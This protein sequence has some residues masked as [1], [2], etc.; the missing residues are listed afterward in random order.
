MKQCKIRTLLILF[1]LLIVNSSVS[2]SGGTNATGVSGR[3]AEP[4]TLLDGGFQRLY[5]LKFADA[6]SQ[7]TAWQ[8]AHTEDPLGD[9]SIAAS[10]LFEEFYRQGVLTAKFFLDDKRLLGG[11]DGKPDEKR[12]AG[13]NKANQRARDSARSR[14]QANS[15]DTDALFALTL[16]TG[17]Q[18]DYASILEKRPLEGLSLIKEANGYAS[19]LL[20]LQP[21]RADAWLALGAA[22][23]IIGC[24][25]MHTRFFLWFGG[26]HGDK[27]LGMEQLMRT[28]DGGHYL[29]PF[30]KIF[31]AL[32]AVREKQED[33]ARRELI[34]LVA[35][36]PDNPLFTAELG[37]LTRPNPR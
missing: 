34:D 20:A 37:E 32:A 21:D 28:A 19:R 26:I 22:N 13:F 1:A 24:L 6:R 36:F 17:M 9:V 23:Y 33:V 18:A 35:E 14:I 4:E 15:K 25:P 5:E 2:H 27:R 30:A 29:R 16:A 8:R 10:Y 7:F 12:T 11:I 31:L 3:S